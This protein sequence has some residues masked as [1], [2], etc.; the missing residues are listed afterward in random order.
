MSLQRKSIP[1]I[2]T[3]TVLVAKAVFPSGNVYMQ[4]RDELGTIY[5]DELFVSVYAE[6]G[7]PA[8]APWRLALV[9]VMQFAENLSDRQA[10]E[11]VRARIDWK[12]ALSLPLDDSGFHYS[13]LSEFRSR[14]LQGS[15][16]S[17]LLDNFLEICQQRGYLRARGRQ[18]TDSTHVLGAVKV[19]NSLELVGETFRHALNVLATVVPE[20]LKQQV[21]PEWFDRYEQRMEDYRLP[22]DKGERAALSTTIGED[23]FFLL[24]SIQQAKEMPWLEKLPAIQTLFKVWEQQ[25]RNVQG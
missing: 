12:Y 5:N 2:P 18:R 11:A 21:K 15:L 22:K 19:L 23:G 4:M 10:A 16:E 3:D 14:L 20:W 17:K 25:Y 7:Q 13:V 9:S 1:D 24:A 6:V 8:I